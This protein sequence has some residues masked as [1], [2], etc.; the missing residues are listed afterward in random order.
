MDE[1]YLDEQYRKKIVM[2]KKEKTSYM[3]EKCTMIIVQDITE[4]QMVEKEIK[5]NE[6]L[7]QTNELITIEMQ[8][9]LRMISKIT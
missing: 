6:A 8:K 5:D 1:P 4:F 3:G 9:P 2:I 7:V